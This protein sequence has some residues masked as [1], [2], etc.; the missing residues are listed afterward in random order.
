MPAA[1]RSLFFL[2]LIASLSNPAVRPGQLRAQAAT[3]D[4]VLRPG[5]VATFAGAGP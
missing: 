2:A 3:L 4:V 5:T 1:R